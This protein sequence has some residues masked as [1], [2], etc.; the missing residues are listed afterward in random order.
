MYRVMIVEDDPMVGE[1]NR[2]YVDMNREFQSV[3]IF[4]N[5]EEGLKYLQKHKTDL[6]IL[7]YYMPMMDGMEF[8]KRI[9]EMDD[10]PEVIMVTAASE[11]DT[12]RK[13]MG[14][15]VVDYLVK[16]FEYERFNQ[17]LLRFKKKRELLDGGDRNLE[18]EKIDELFDGG[19]KPSA[20]KGKI[21]KGFQEHT[22]ERVRECIRQNKEKLFTSEEIAEAVHLSRVTI[23]RY[24]NYMLE[25]QEIVSTIDYQTGGRP[26]I[27][28]KWAG[29]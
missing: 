22:L 4:G 16:P 2:K 15:G 13:L 12:V 26:S 29:K 27:K 23:R 28:Y 17:A 7:D 24:V 10:C 21:Q 9:K 8:L 11:A 3:G 18:Q 20:E 14:V 25:S 1:I 6:V 19:I 5:G